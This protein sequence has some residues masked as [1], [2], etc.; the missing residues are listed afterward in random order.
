[1]KFKV[2]RQWWMWVIGIVCNILA[3]RFLQVDGLYIMSV[4]IFIADV[5]IIFPDIHLSYVIENKCLTVNRILPKK[6]IPCNTI[7]S[8][9]SATLLTVGGFA[10]K[11]YE[12]KLGSYKI[13]YLDEI[14]KRRAVIVSPKNGQEF[15]SELDLYID[16][17]VNL[18]N[19]TESAFKKKKDDDL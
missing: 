17:E 12:N 2:K 3:V 7:M 5:F 15:M 9:E 19:N 4:I 11:I 13:T 1:M 8:V 16:R 6:V 10:L 14:H 18:L